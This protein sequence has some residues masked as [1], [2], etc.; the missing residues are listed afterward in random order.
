MMLHSMKLCAD[1]LNG[2]TATPTEAT[3]AATAAA[4]RVA[5]PSATLPTPV[6]IVN[7]NANAAISDNNNL[8]TSNTA[9]S[10]ASIA[11]LVSNG[12]INS[13]NNNSSSNGIVHR[14]LHQY[15]GK[16]LEAPTASKFHPYLRPTA[17]LANEN[18]CSSPT[19]AG[20]SAFA[21]TLFPAFQS[22][23]NSN[24][25]ANKTTVTTAVVGGAV[26]ATTAPS[27]LLTLPTTPL[28][29]VSNTTTTNSNNN[30]AS[31]TAA[32]F[33]NSDASFG[34]GNGGV[35]NNYTTARFASELM[36]ENEDINSAQP[37]S[38]EPN[39]ATEAYAESMLTD[40]CSNL[41]ALSNNNCTNGN[42]VDNTNGDATVENE[43][44]KDQ[45]DPDNIKMFVGQIPKSWDEAQLRKMFEQYGRVHTLNVLR[46]KVT[47]VSRGCCFV[48]Y[49]TRKA[50]L[51]AQDAL[52]NIKTL[53]GMHHPIQMKPADSENRN[54]RK[55][56]VGMLNKKYNEAD[57]RQLFT[58][59][60]TIE[61]C[62]VLRDQNGQ[63]KGCAFVTFATKH[64]A[65]GAIKALHQSRTMEGCSAPLVVK[66]ADTQKEKDQ[67]KM[68]QLQASL[69][70]ITAL[71]TPST[72]SIAGL[73]ATPTNGL[74][75]ASGATLVPSPLT[76]ASVRSNS[77][78]SAA[79]AAVA[80]APQPTAVANPASALVPTSAAISVSPS[81]LTA[82]GTAAQQASPYLT[83]TD[84]MNASAAQLHLF[85]QLQAFGL[86]PAQYLQGLNFPPD[87]SVTTA[88][89]S[90]AAAA[91]TAAANH[92]TAGA[93]DASGQPSN[94]V[95]NG[96]L[97]ARSIPM[98]N[99]VTLAALGAH[100]YSPNQALQSH[101][102]LIPSS[103]QQQS[104]HQQQQQRQIHGL[105]YA[106][107]QALSASNQ[108]QAQAHM[109][110]LLQ[111]PLTMTAQLTGATAANLW[112]GGE[113]LTSPYAPTLSPLTNGAAFA[114][115]ATPLTTTALQ[116]AA[117]GVAGKQVEGPDG[118]NLFIY[119]LPQEFTDTDLA[120]TF[121]PFGNVLSAKV[122]ID[123]QTNLSK[124]F[125]FVSY[126]NPLSAGAAIQ[127]MHGFQIGTKRLKVQLKRSKDAAKPY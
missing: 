57:V 127:A 49:Y 23:V 65:I 119:H 7:A 62:T 18:S 66:F 32:A 105:S 122:F 82:A 125:G 111:S 101:S 94:T 85:Q 40:D 24:V 22:T 89:L 11:S 63:S 37:S 12:N 103:Q 30:S 88:S 93:A 117:A 80:A 112:P 6:A 54:E 79:L 28:T 84:A 52:H 107:A 44:N 70:G 29:A 17:V 102:H 78:M 14:Q 108:A 48:T 67:K 75:P 60:G 86:H 35:G 104:Q 76:A 47:S 42:A 83:T 116:A 41:I 4:M 98:Q 121:L 36:S 113:S 74:S 114:T 69:V 100:N 64:N 20:T 124:C 126:D 46:D 120:S 51:K 8:N 1:Q 33:I 21:A 99:L 38:S 71:T 43:F 19:V 109:A 58:G 55:L 16:Y 77:S 110:H 61:E 118:S 5:N 72:G 50:A 106:P 90:A 56:F 123:K 68:Q 95:G 31:A 27:G 97:S 25:A 45:P 115:T 9:A 10:I 87:H 96:L 39:R 53:E 15:Q 34:N 3:A 26:N 91:A 73:A 2:I 81:L 13:G 92:A 59:H